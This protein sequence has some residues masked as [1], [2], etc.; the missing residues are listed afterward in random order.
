MFTTKKSAHTCN[1]IVDRE[2]RGRIYKAEATFVDK[3][4][5]KLCATINSLLRPALVPAPLVFKQFSGVGYRT[6]Q[7]NFVANLRS[8]A[9]QRD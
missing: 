4:K 3:S 2:R 5:L 6:E 7:C 8:S 9:F 1:Y